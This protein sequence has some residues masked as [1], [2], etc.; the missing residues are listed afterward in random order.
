MSV[1]FLWLQR[2]AVLRYQARQE[3]QVDDL[4]GVSRA[5]NGTAKLLNYSY[6]IATG[7]RVLQ[8]SKVGC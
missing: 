7:P 5:T 1:P 2:F 4:I 3:R 6:V 8:Q